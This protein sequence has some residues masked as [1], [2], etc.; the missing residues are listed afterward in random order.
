MYNYDPAI[1]EI[2]SI[3]ADYA[4]NL[5]YLNTKERASFLY[6]TFEQK[7]FEETL[8][9]YPVLPTKFFDIRGIV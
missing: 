9:R 7:P 4:S 6:G 5:M 2:R 3:E 1:H 8:C